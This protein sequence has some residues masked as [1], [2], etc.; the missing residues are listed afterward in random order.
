MGYLFDSYINPTNPAQTF[1]DLSVDCTPKPDP[2]VRLFCNEI[3]VFCGTNDDCSR[4]IV[5]NGLVLCDCSDTWNNDLCGNDLPFCYQF[6]S[7]D[8]YTFQFQQPNAT[9]S[10]DGWASNGTLITTDPF[11]YFEIRKCCDDSLVFVDSALFDEFVV[12]SFVGTF[13]LA[14]FSGSLSE[15]Q[16]QQIQFDLGAIAEHMISLGDDPCFYFKFCFSKN[17]SPIPYPINFNNVDCFCTENFRLETCLEKPKSVL[18]D[19][20][21]SSTDCFGQYFGTD[22]NDI[23][24]GTP[25]QFS[26]QIRVPGYFEPTNFTITKNVIESSR[27]TTGMELCETWLLRTMPMPLRFARLLATIIAGADVFINGREYQFQGE[28]P[29][30][31]E[32]GSRW[33]ADLQFEYCDCSKNLTC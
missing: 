11:A 25:F 13:N 4:S 29:K 27:K 7:G 6:Q 28:F 21:Y 24:S 3:N 5:N 26:N 23:Q 14:N 2:L 10:N 33:C 18:I 22:W 20:R 30:N 17:Q 16:I 19:S 8:L 31:N 15:N 1:C 9:S 32:T 12:G